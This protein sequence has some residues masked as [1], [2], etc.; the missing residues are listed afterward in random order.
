[1]RSVGPFGAKVF[2]RD[3]LKILE[4]LSDGRF[5]S[6]V[7]LG[8]VIGKT[9]SSVLHNIKNIAESGIC[10]NRVVGRGYQ[11]QHVPCFYDENSLGS[12]AGLLFFDCVESTNT[13][14]LGR[15]D[16]PDG[17]VAIAGFQNGGKGR[18]G[19]KFI[20]RYGDQIMFSYACRFNEIAEISGLSIVAGVSVVK[21]LR[22]AG[23]QNIGL[24]WPNDIYVSGKKAG[25]VLVETTCDSDGVF[26]VIGIGLNV[27]RGF[28]F[29]S[30]VHNID[31]ELNT[32][33]VAGNDGRSR[34]DLLLKFCKGLDADLAEYR[35]KGLAPFTDY[36]NGCDVFS[37][38]QVVLTNDNVNIFGT[39]LGISPSG[40]L[41]IRD[42]NNIKREIFA[43]DISLRPAASLPD[44]AG[45]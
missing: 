10:F 37:G 15:T 16:V 7:E 27:E 23:Q 3:E 6:G 14:L 26:V 11:L 34:A 41:I 42:E 18:R 4:V 36:F 38:R 33:D 30:E 8:E 2:S 12:R 31:R 5:H 39:C 20:S 1:M 17:T 44:C 22:A 13:Y 45:H 24:K 35:R 32:I 21:T 40:S 9:R 43:G 25:G 19:R 29:S 28:L